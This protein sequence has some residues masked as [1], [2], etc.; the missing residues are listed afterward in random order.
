MKHVVSPSTLALSTLLFALSLIA[1][2]AV[3]NQKAPVPDKAALAEA[4]AL[5][6]EVYGAQYKAARTVEQRLDLAR[7]LLEQAKQ[8]AGDPVGRYALLQVAR[9]IAANAGEVETVMEAAEMIARWYDVDALEMRI[10][11]LRAAGSAAKLPGQRQAVA[12]QALALVDEAIAAER[13]ETASSLATM[14]ASEARRARQYALAKEAMARKQQVD[15]LAKAAAT[16][17]EVRKTLES[18]PTN[19]EAN[20]A[21]GRFHGV[22]K[23]QWD[24][25]IPMLALGSDPE[26][27]SL[28]RTELKGVSSAEA[29]VELADGWWDLAQGR[30]GLD[31]DAFLRRA[32]YWYGQAMPDLDSVLLKVKAS[33]RLEEISKVG[34][35]VPKASGAPRRRS[36]P[37]GVAPFDAKQAM[38]HQQAWARYLGLPVTWTNSLGMQFVLIPPGEFEMGSTEEEVQRLLA[39]AKQRGARSGTLTRIACEAPKHRVKITRPFYLGV[40]E[41]TQQQYERVMG[42]N[43]SQFPGEPNRPLERVTWDEAAEFCRKLGQLTEEEAANAVYALPTEAQWE[44]A[45]RAGTTTRF[46]FGGDAAALEGGAGWR[47]IS[48]GTTHPVRGKTPNAWGLFDLHESLWEWCAD[49]WAEDYYGR[50]PTDDPAGPDSGRKRVFR[51]A[52]RSARRDCGYPASRGSVGFRVGRILAP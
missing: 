21:L 40:S 4:R 2:P 28:A 11:C 14:A 24:Q 37:L 47:P 36:P 43:P 19:A 29:K 30:E 16:L 1:G 35:P 13:Y 22:V 20:L 3:A 46:S 15:E 8:A 33:K 12:E 38:K 31:R 41:V 5:L 23:E 51:G 44:Y 50:S 49:W 32:G 25:A 7:K 34:Q 18:D 17:S 26:L 52:S 9:E 10:D 39:E 6:G 27:A 42:A 48:R 45:C